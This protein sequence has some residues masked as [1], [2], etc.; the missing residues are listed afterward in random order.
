MMNQEAYTLGQQMTSDF[1]MAEE[2]KKGLDI[3]THGE[4]GYRL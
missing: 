2:E 3:A 4:E 1:P